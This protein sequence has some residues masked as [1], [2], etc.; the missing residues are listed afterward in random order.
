MIFHFG[1]PKNEASSQFLG[2]PSSEI[3]KCQKCK[4]TL[5]I[6]SGK[7][8]EAKAVAKSLVT[9]RIEKTYAC[10]K[11]GYTHVE[12]IT[13]KQPPKPQQASI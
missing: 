12:N 4:T 3:K 10:S 8:G 9:P 6:K 5:V 13:T 2:A 11:C 1:I 7:K